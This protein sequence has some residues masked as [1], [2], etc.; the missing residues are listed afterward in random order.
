MIK[1]DSLIVNSMVQSII[2]KNNYILHVHFKIMIA[3]RKFTVIYNCIRNGDMATIYFFN[4]NKLSFVVR[5]TDR[6]KQFWFQFCISIKYII[7]I[8][9]YN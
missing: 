1:T 8:S 9:L 7:R 3:Y 6:Q 2:M 4:T 5:K